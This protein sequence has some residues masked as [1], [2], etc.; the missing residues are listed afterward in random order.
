MPFFGQWCSMDDATEQG[1]HKLTLVGKKHCISTDLATN[2]GGDAPWHHQCPA[3][4]VRTSGRPAA[5]TEG[6]MP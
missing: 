6:N 3:L 5:P 1:G 2:G 4:G